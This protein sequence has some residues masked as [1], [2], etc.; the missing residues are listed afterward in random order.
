MEE[1]PQ[2]RRSRS[3]GRGWQRRWSGNGGG[4][5]RR[6]VRGRVRVEWRGE[7]EGRPVGENRMALAVARVRIKRYC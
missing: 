3:V 7:N 1:L 5:G 2:W 6:E 4:G